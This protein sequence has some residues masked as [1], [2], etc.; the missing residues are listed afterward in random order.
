MND[1]GEQTYSLQVTARMTGLN[2]DTILFYQEQGFVRCA[3]TG[4]FDDEAL[5][6]LRRIEH[7]REACGVN[8]E[9]VKL[10]LRLMD[11]LERVKMAER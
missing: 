10:I 11:E 4:D 8:D 9:G 1:P 5:R 2:E 3:V 7:L 6:T